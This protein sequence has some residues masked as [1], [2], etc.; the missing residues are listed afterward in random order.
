MAFSIRI[1]LERFCR[2]ISGMVVG[3]ISDWKAASV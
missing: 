3:S 1:V 2:W